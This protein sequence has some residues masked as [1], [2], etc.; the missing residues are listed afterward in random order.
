MIL[1]HELWQTAF[2]GRPI[3]GQTIDVANRP[4]EV[5]GIMPPGADL[6]DNQTA[7]WLPLGLDPANPGDRLSHFLCV[8]GRLRNGATEEAAQAELNALNANWGERVG[9]T[10]HMFALM[11]S[12]NAPSGT[13]S[14]SAGHLL[15]M[16]PL[17]DQIV[18][19]AR[20]PI[21]MLQLAAGLVML[22]ACANL[23][24]LLLARAETRHREFAVRRALGATRGRLLTQS[25]AE[26]ALLSI[27]GG[28]LALWIAH[29]GLRTLTQSYPAA[30]PRTAETSVDLPVLLFTCGV[31]AV[32]GI[33]FGLAQLRHT[34]A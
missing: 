11:P 31:A 8:I 19:A 4:R 17:Q 20:R 25:I 18:G 26:G 15:Q 28:A 5:L 7:I 2:G 16:T 1:S 29:V 32:T 23:A 22:I 12:K 34:G 33:F 24:N 30:L 10:E 13:R 3:I 21:W 9:V 14:S 27:V 6:M